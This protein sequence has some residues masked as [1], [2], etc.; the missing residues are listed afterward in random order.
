MDG[1]LRMENGLIYMTRHPEGT[2]DGSG[3]QNMLNDIMISVCLYNIYY[4]FLN[5]VL[6]Y[7]LQI[8][9]EEVVSI[10]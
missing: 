6:L 1:I 2:G 3:F 5:S 7:K 10:I 9:N 4:I 8:T